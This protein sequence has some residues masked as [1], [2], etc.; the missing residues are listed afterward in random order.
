MN[1]FGN[2]CSLNS[3]GNYYDYNSFGNNCGGNTFGDKCNS[4]RFGN[5]CQNNSF[6][7]NCSSNKFG[8]NFQ[9]S[10]LGEGVQ[11][12]KV[13]IGDAEHVK[14][15]QILNGTQGTDSS[16]LL[17]INFV[18]DAKYSQFAGF[19]SDGVLETWVE[20]DAPHDVVDGGSY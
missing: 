14:Y 4:N 17:E 16:N 13:A 5:G 12:V 11:Y 19:K 2:G 1:S 9:M 8:N 10:T 3:F 6:G 15:V 20:A 7:N 18:K